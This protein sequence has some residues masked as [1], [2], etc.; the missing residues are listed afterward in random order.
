MLLITNPR[1]AAESHSAC[2]CGTITPEKNAKHWNCGL[3]GLPR[4]SDRSRSHRWWSFAVRKVR[5]GVLAASTNKLGP[6]MPT[7][8]LGPRMKGAVEQMN[9]RSAEGLRELAPHVEWVRERLLLG[10]AGP[11]SSQQ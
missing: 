5:T 8:E 9:A 6:R 1:Y 4:W 2:M 11:N 3:S 7:N 10:V